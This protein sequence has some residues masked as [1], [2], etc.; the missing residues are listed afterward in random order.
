MNAENI[1]MQYEKYCEVLKK[2]LP[3]ESVENLMNTLGE[4]LATSPRGLTLEDGG[5]PGALVDFSL[6][7]AGIAKSMSSN[8]GDTKSLVKVALLHELGKLGDIDKKEPLFIPQDSQWHQEKLGQMYK[9]NDKCPK[10]NI[11][12]RTLWILSNLKIDLTRNEWEAIN[13]SQGLHLQ[14]NQFYANSISNVS[15]GL[16]ASRL[17]ILFGA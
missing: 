2:V 11:A 6:K 16:L 7:A 14:E 4:N 3:E 5:S 9:Y 17:A 1:L 15:A 8:F 12:H 10:M 13:V